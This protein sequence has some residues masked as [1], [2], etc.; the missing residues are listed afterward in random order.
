MEFNKVQELEISPRERKAYN[1]PEKKLDT[2]MYVY[3]YI[4]IPAT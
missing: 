4:Y 2:P 1:P 3:I